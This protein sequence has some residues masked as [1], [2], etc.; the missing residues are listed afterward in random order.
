M[1]WALLQAVPVWTPLDLLPIAVCLILTPPTAA[2]DELAMQLVTRASHYMKG[3]VSSTLH[4]VTP[5]RLD[6]YCY[7]GLLMHSYALVCAHAY[8]W[9]FYIVQG[10]P[11]YFCRK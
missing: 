6:L 7:P 4:C 10:S 11:M 8:H 5:Q 1:L 2:A 9:E 3:L